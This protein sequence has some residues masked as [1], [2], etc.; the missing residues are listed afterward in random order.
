MLSFAKAAAETGA[1]LANTAYQI[2]RDRRTLRR[3]DTAYQR[4]ANDMRAA[5]LNP[6]LHN[7][8]PAGASPGPQDIGVSSAVQQRAYNAQIALQNAQ[9][10]S[11][12][13]SSARDLAT[14]FHDLGINLGPLSARGHINSRNPKAFVDTINKMLGSVGLDQLQLRGMGVNSA[15]ALDDGPDESTID[16]KKTFYQKQK[17]RQQKN[18]G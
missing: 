5:G 7:V 15:K 11:T 2:Y 3:E 14:T 4:A 13:V 18:N 9:A 1:H 10:L 16:H 12:V 17:E 6:L 8:S